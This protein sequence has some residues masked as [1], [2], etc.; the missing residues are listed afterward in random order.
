MLAD[1][2][3]ERRPVGFCARIQLTGGK[4][5]HPL[6]L[7][8]A[9]TLAVAAQDPFVEDTTRQVGRPL[10]LERPKVANRDPRTCGDSFQLHAAL[11]PLLLKIPS[12][13]HVHLRYF[14]PAAKR[15]PLPRDPG[16][17]AAWAPEE[18]QAEEPSARGSSL[19]PPD[20]ALRPP[21]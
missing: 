21:R 20:E 4:A 11:N 2:L 18:A 13:P 3:G 12:E 1:A 9:N 10:I 14:E 5:V 16:T 6:P 8:Q 7:L 15:W 19:F 17:T